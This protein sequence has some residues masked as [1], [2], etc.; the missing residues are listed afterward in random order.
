MHKCNR[1]TLTRDFHL[2]GYL[3]NALPYFSDL[4][5][6]EEPLL[7]V[8][9]SPSGTGSQTVF[10]FSLPVLKMYSLRH[11]YYKERNVAPVCIR[12]HVYGFTS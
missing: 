3:K 4:S 7:W 8:S 11:V 10:R 6:N 12:H 5:Q 9:H 1:V 2:L